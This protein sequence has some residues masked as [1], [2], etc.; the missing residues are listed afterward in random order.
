MVQGLVTAFIDGDRDACAVC[1]HEHVVHDVPGR[2]PMSGRYKGREAVLA[3]CVKRKQALQGKQYRS[4]I[5]ST[6]SS[7]E[8]VAMVTSV[9]AESR[10]VAYTWNDTLVFFFEDGKVAACWMFV[11]H[12]DA[13]NEF[14]NDHE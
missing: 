1:L 13:F 12:M 11:D 7:D 6:S 5:V 2:N 3:M 14:W 8:H 9:H 4:K 10:G